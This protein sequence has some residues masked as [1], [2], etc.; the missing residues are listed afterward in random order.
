VDEQRQEHGPW[1]EEY[2]QRFEK[3]PVEPKAKHIGVSANG[4]Y[5]AIRAS[6]DG[7]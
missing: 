7:D 2:K 1:W 5:T 3:P 6:K 4:Q